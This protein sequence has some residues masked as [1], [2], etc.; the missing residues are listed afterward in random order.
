MLTLEVVSHR[1]LCQEGLAALGTPVEG[2]GLA[3]VLMAHARI[4]VT[5]QIALAREIDGADGAVEFTRRSSRK[6]A[7]SQR[8]HVIH[9]RVRCHCFYVHLLTN[10]TTRKMDEQRRASC[11]SVLLVRSRVISRS[12]RRTLFAPP[13]PS[14]SSLLIA[15][16]LDDNG[17]VKNAHGLKLRP[18]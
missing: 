17:R 8:H 11:V 9:V 1:R 6:P 14:P 18:T 12:S 13:P 3:S 5:K 10:V 4:N 15:L 7:C 16:Q 2:F